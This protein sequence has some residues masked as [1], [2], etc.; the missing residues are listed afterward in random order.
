M[1]KY[2]LRT[3]QTDTGHKDFAYN[4]PLMLMEVINKFLFVITLLLMLFF[5]YS[6]NIIHI[7][8]IY[9]LFLNIALHL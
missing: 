3:N 8:I 5:I 2:L 6:Y 7:I 4:T 1:E 9:Y